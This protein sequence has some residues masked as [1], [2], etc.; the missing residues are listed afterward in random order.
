MPDESLPNDV[1]RRSFL[2]G[3]AIGGAA[4]ALADFLSP[5]AA[6]AGK[7]PP[8]GVNYRTSPNGA[9]R[10]DKCALWQSPNACK[11]VAGPIAPAG[12]C[13]LFKKK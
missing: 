13:V 5:S 6:C 3:A 8:K 12:W 10:C 11:L 2:R 4:V 9:Q 1:S 7:M